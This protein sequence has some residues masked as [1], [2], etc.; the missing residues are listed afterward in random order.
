MM[1]FW[2]EQEPER[3]RRHH[4]LE[5]T[6]TWLLNGDQPT[7]TVCIARRQTAGRG[8]LGRSWENADG[9]ALLF[10]GMVSGS[11][12]VQ[13]DRFRLAPILVGAA[14]FLAI[15]NLMATAVDV[16]P[17]RPKIKWPNDIYWCDPAGEGKLAGVLLESRL[18]RPPPGGPEGLTN[19]RLVL[20]IGLNWQGVPEA[21]SGQ[22]RDLFPPGPVPSPELLIGLFVKSLGSLG[23]QEPTEWLDVFR[24]NDFLRGRSV[25]LGGRTLVCEGIDERGRLMLAGESGRPVFLEDT[26][27]EMELLPR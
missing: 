5:S 3:W 1:Q 12:D 15:E 16:R 10:S 7:G 18:A 19:V 14:L 26:V 23:E 6:N 25:V 11:F 21:L 9:Q 24:T 20:G 2:L 8:R 27:P 13:S 17:G 4:E 22:A